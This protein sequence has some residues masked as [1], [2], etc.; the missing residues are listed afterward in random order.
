MAAEALRYTRFVMRSR[1]S[2]ARSSVNA[3]LLRRTESLLTH[4]LD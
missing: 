1:I 2:K 3:A 4:A